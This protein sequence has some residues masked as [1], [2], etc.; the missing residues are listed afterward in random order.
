MEVR[1]VFDLFHEQWREYDYSG[2]VY[3]IDTPRRLWI[4]ATTHR[5][6]DATG[7]VHCVPAPGFH[8]CALR[9]QPRDPNDPVQF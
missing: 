6:Q 9:W 3:R 1:D 7:L 5:V 4:G 8:G 2:R